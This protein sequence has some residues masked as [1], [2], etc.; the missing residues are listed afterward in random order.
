MTVSGADQA[1]GTDAG[2]RPWW[3]TRV[4]VAVAILAAAIPLIYPAIPPLV[5]LLGHMGRYRVE[6][7]LGRSPWLHNY[8][9]YHWAAIGNLGVD[10]LMMGLAPVMGL[11]PAIKL[12]VIAIPPLTVAGFLWVAR[13]VHGRV[14]PTAYFAI[15]FAYG[16]PFMFGFVNF[17]LSMAFAFLAFGL[18]L[19]LGRLG[20]TR[21]RLAL[22][23]PISLI[24]FFTHTYGWGALGL[25][26]FSAEAVRQH[27]R[28]T[29]WFQAGLNAAVQ[30]SIMALP[31]LVMIIWRS[32]THGGSTGDWFNWQAKL[33]WLKAALRDRWQAYDVISVVAMGL[34]LV[35]ALRNPRLTFSRNLAFSGLVLI[36]AYILLPRII[37]GSAYADMRLVPYAIAVLLIA[38]RFRGATPPRLAQA[39][40]ILALIFVVVRLGSNTVS[41]ARAADDQQAKLAA[42]NHVPMGARVATFVGLPCGT[43]WALARN[44][45]L[46]AM[47]MVRRDGFSNDQWLIEGVNLQDLR[48]TAPGYFAAD[49]S[50][51]VR[52]DRCP[53][54]IHRTIDASLAEVPRSAFD[55]IWLI[56]ITSQDPKLIQGLTPVWRGPGS[57]LY[58]I[59]P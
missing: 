13:E 11:E 23:A 40:A 31:I 37:F 59:Q 30:A 54:R 51:I 24:V 8:Y 22:F 36:A 5:D 27:D 41:L 57:I 47:V 33:I 38:I 50:N 29:K 49:P 10:L 45:H 6:L 9:S 21:L 16:H 25:M 20:R 44:S 1:Y 39:L 43:S 55:Y 12:I 48:Y 18:W 17:A 58:R 26:C 46:G 56:D 42:I 32:E 7:D 15:P 2:H 3:E 52:P 28:G 19:R 34:L 35:E 4:A 14:P 53:D